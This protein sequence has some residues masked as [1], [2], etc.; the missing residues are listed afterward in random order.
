MG[1][2]F[3]YQLVL[4]FFYMGTNLEQIIANARNQ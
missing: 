2:K 4:K 3:K 1:A